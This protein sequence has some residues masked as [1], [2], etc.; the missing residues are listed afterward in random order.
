MNESTVIFEFD[1][2]LRAR[3]DEDEAAINAVY[4]FW[5][6]HGERGIV[7]KSYAAILIPD[8]DPAT[9]AY[10]L[11]YGPE[12]ALHELAAKRA[13]LDVHSPC[14][15]VTYP[16]PS[17]QPTCAVCQTGLWDGEAEDWPCATI[18]AIAAV[19]GDHPDYRKEW[20]VN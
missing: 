1:T 6:S 14:Y 20:S 9:R 13:I 16:E 8:V 19:Y 10:I 7:D 11:R 4:G 5:R 2:V 18:R 12:R 15:P 3:L 17:G